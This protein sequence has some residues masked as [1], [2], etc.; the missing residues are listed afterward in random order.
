MKMDLKEWGVR[1]GI[2]FMWL[3]TRPSGGFL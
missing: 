1:T 3:R 2:R